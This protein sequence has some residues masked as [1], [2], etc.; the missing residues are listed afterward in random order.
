MRWSWQGIL[1]YQLVH[2]S[3]SPYLEVDSHR[4][5]SESACAGT[6][7]APAGGT[8]G[9]ACCQSPPARSLAA[10]ACWRTP[11]PPGRSPCPA[12]SGPARRSQQYRCLHTTCVVPLTSRHSLLRVLCAIPRPAHRYMPQQAWRVAAL[13]ESACA[14][15]QR[16]WMY[17]ADSS[18][19]ATSARS[20]MRTPWKLA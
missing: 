11:R 7:S 15:R 17:R 14:A 2:G 20:S 13:Q 8:S 9:A 1:A 19:A 5:V 6:G 12:G 18:A 4:L 16:A 10:R 3:E